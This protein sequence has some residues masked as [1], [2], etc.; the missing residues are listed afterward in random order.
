MD[1]GCPHYEVFLPRVRHLQHI[2]RSLLR[3]HPALQFL[4]SLSQ[5]TADIPE[6]L[7]VEGN[8]LLGSSSKRSS[9]LQPRFSRSAF[10]ADP[11]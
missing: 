7:P 6:M 3:T 8:V 4:F 11:P 10:V 9:K 1:S 2:N 5:G